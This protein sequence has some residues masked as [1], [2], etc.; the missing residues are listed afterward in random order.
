[1]YSSYNS[2]RIVSW[3]V[4]NPVCSLT[5]I[6]RSIAATRMY[7]ELYEVGHSDMVQ[8]LCVSFVKQ[9]VPRIDFSKHYSIA[10][11][12]NSESTESGGL[13]VVSQIKATR[14]SSV[15]SCDN[16]TV[17]LEMNQTRR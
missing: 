15:D 7:R 11:R 1:M 17:L 2:L 14:D 13:R 4:C 6:L 16:A 12:Q 3:T 9:Y 5:S 10:T 8:V